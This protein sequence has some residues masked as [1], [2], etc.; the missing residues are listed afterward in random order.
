MSGYI[1][2][3]CQR[4]LGIELNEFAIKEM[5][6]RA[7]NMKYLAKNCR[8]MEQVRKNTTRLEELYSLMVRICL[9]CHSLSKRLYAARLQTLTHGVARK[10]TKI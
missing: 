6:I 9:S 8:S 10:F 2:M 3:F 1:L 5:Y 4:T 7:Q